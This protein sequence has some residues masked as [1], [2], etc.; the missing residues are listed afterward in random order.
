LAGIAH[1]TVNKLADPFLA[2]NRMQR[3]LR[4]IIALA[5]RLEADD[6][7]LAAHL[8]AAKAKTAKVL[9]DAER[10]LEADAELQAKQ[11]KQAR[12]ARQDTIRKAVRLAAED[13]WDDENVDSAARDD[14]SGDGNDDH[15]YRR[16][17]LLDDLF[18]DYD[19]SDSWDGDPVEIVATLCA[20]LGLKPKADPSLDVDDGDKP[21][22]KQAR[23]LELARGY[24]REAGW[25]PEPA[26]EPPAAN[27]RGPPDG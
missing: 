3:E 15:R 9:R 20:R 1:E 24:L 18:D 25:V 26:D 6:L 23:T 21:V 27:G 12:Q 19:T 5:E 22:E 17:N 2:I 16:E 11:A 4:R 8:A 10:W 7:Q 13:G 14:D